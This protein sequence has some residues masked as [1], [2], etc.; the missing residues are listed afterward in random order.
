[1]LLSYVGDGL[2]YRCC[3]CRNGDFECK[4]KMK[5]SFICSTWNGRL[6]YVI[7]LI[8][9]N[10]NEL[11]AVKQNSLFVVILYGATLRHR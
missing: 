5:S 11:N 10:R 6:L 2:I 8:E 9:S 3:F 1:M 7:N 4:R